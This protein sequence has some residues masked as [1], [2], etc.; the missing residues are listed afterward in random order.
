MS[1]VNETKQMNMNE[2]TLFQQIAV[3][4]EV[5][6]IMNECHT[7]N[8]KLYFAY[9]KLALC[10]DKYLLVFKNEFMKYI[11]EDKVNEIVGY[12]YSEI[13]PVYLFADKFIREIKSMLGTDCGNLRL[14]REPIAVIKSKFIVG[15]REIL[16]Y[17]P[18]TGTA[19]L[20]CI[21]GKSEGEL[22]FLVPIVFALKQNVD[23]TII[24]QSV[25]YDVK[26]K[27]LS[28][29]I[30]KAPIMNLAIEDERLK[31]GIANEGL[32]KEERVKNALDTLA[33][34]LSSIV[35]DVDEDDEDMAEKLVYVVEKI[36]KSNNAVVFTKEFETQQQA[37][38]YI[39]NTVKDYPEIAKRFNFTVKVVEVY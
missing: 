30:N 23:N 25:G 27:L 17:I 24:E 19:L 39:K 7:D 8:E 11:D 13:I 28:T 26:I 16:T 29:P 38:D 1:N 36:D 32:A 20:D 9:L 21:M 37:T 34:V 4:G 33:G 22:D 35:N 3:E 5:A 2:L 31:K 15:M 18:E 12:R 6:A 10:E 14:F